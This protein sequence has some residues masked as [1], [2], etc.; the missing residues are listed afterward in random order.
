MEKPTTEAVWP[1]YENLA[2]KTMG[3]TRDELLQPAFHAMDK[4]D[5]PELYEESIGILASIR[6]ISKLMAVTGV[7]DFSTMDIF[8]PESSRTITNL[9]AI[10]N[11]LKF[12]QGRERDLEDVLEERDR[13]CSLY[14]QSEER[15]AVLN[16]EIEAIEADRRAQ[17]PA[18]Q[19]LEAETKELNQE[20]QVLNKQHGALN[21]DIRALKQAGQAV[22][23]EISTEKFSLIQLKEERARLKRQ[24]VQSPQKLQRS[25]AE[26]KAALISSKASAE[27][28]QQL[29]NC[30]KDKIE[31]YNKVEKKLKKFLGMLDELEKL[32]IK[33]KATVKE[34]KALK[35]QVKSIEEEIESLD[36]ELSQLKFQEQHWLD[37]TEKLEQQGPKKLQE[38]Q[39]EL[40]ETKANCLP[41]L[42]RIDE[43]GAAILKAEEQVKEIR[44]KTEAMH[45]KR[46]N[47]IA[48]GEAA[49]QKIKKETLLHF[50]SLL[51]LGPAELVS[52]PS[53]K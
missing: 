31:A 4:L 20:I 12:K 28:A 39:R 46:D 47:T 35:A 48:R 50:R 21:S 15:L 23:E 11:L 34:K 10:I 14:Q 7:A 41:L 43:R 18:V 6:A 25:L 45:K 38:A 3:K 36:T 52:V 2:L 9:S 33:Q 24:I 53:V 44:L 13:V 5:Y 22:A 16:S 1:I 27:E 19:V 32:W 8:K 49:V 26:K 17:Q 40:N 37:L 30:W 42:A 29:L 51:E